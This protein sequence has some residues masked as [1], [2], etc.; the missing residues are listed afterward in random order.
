MLDPVY[1]E[2]VGV[3]YVNRPTQP[4]R[5]LNPD[6]GEMQTFG[7]FTRPLPGYRGSQADP[8]AGYR[9]AGGITSFGAGDYMGLGNIFSD[10]FRTRTGTGNV[11][12]YTDVKEALPEYQKL[13]SDVLNRDEQRDRTKSNILFNIAEAGL[14]FAAGVDASGQSVTD[15]PIISQ[16][17]AAAKGLPTQI[18]AQ[19]DR[20]FTENQ[21]LKVAALNQAITQTAQERQLEA[22]L[23]SAE[24]IS[25]INSYMRAVMDKG[26]TSDMYRM[27]SD[28]QTIQAWSQGAPLPY[29][30]NALSRLFSPRMDPEGGMV[31]PDIPQPI[32]DAARQRVSLSGGSIPAILERAL[33]APTVAAGA[34]GGAVSAYASGGGVQKF[35][36][37]QGVVS[38]QYLNDM[39]RGRGFIPFDELLGAGVSPPVN[40]AEQAGRTADAG[41]WINVPMHISG[42]PYT[43]SQGQGQRPWMLVAPVSPPADLPDVPEIMVGQSMEGVDPTTA[44]GPLNTLKG[45]GNVVVDY[46]TG[47]FDESANV[48]P[49]PQ[50]RAADAAISQINGELEIAIRNS[51]V[52]RDN[53]QTQ[54]TIERYLIPE[55][56][57]TGDPAAHNQ[58][59]TTLSFLDTQIANNQNLL[60]NAAVTGTQRSQYEMAEEQL[61][62]VRE[63]LRLVS[64]G[65]ERL[66]NPAGDIRD[67][68]LE[69]LYGTGGSP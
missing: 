53:L 2:G 49:A 48:S 27:I 3:R 30:D 41:S 59:K 63:E 37:G 17:A 9:G 6:T 21:A 8:L 54:A 25:R 24:E 44:T 29:F 65:Y 56:V 43:V 26:S 35:Q 58:I 69:A 42:E 32:I 40:T 14:N 64:A 23:L 16:A 68:D 52:D 39:D 18:A 12:L 67:I 62:A 34:S 1:E 50:M 47:I 55:G 7:Q 20:A 46:I 5:L 51:L 38:P 61:K 66:L 13:F 45:L 10:K 4:L 11:D 28:P 31:Y 33:A 57:F 60:K 19:T 36:Q 22:Q 15:Q